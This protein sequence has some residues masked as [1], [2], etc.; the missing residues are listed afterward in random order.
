MCD[1]ASIQ[2]A[3]EI[4]QEKVTAGEMFTA[5]DVTRVARKRG[6][7][8]RH[9]H[10]KQVI[11][12][13]FAAGAMGNDYTRTLIRMPGAKRDAWLYHRQQ[14]DPL[15]Y[16]AGRASPVARGRRSVDRRRRLCVPTQPLR[17]AGL[18]PG[19]AVWVTADSQ[20]QG[21]VLT[22]TKP[23]AAVIGSYRVERSGNI[24]ITQRVFRRAGL[25]GRAFVVDADTTAIHVRRA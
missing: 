18:A 2:M 25:A 8:E 13:V 4:V 23:G 16:G 12:A 11:H 7:P 3:E 24:R 15:R 20:G 5:F 22:R 19:D 21:V 17:Q 14:D 10:L 6:S 1:I 9:R